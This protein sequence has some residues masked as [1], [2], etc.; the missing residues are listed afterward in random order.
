M[1]ELVSSDREMAV[2]ATRQYGIVA[3]RQLGLDAHAIRRRTAA[4]RL[5][6]VHRGVYAVGHLGLGQEARWLAAVLACGDGALLSHRSAATLWGI[7]LGE[8]FRPE[9]TT[10][11]TGAIPASRPIGPS[12][13]RRTAPPTEGSRSPAPPA[14]WP[15]SRTSWTTTS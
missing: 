11:T 12:W 7:R 2:L 4:G 10:S 9:V 15:T 5:H 13:P 1:R 6:R 3:G 14:R 8:L